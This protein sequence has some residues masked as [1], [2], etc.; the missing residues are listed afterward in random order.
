MIF[1]GFFIRFFKLLILWV[2]KGKK[3]KTAKNGPKWEK[4][5]SHSVSQESY[6][7]WFWFMVLV[8][9]MKIY[10]WG[11]FIF[12]KFWFSGLLGG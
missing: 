9:K 10:P 7:V 4:I 3:C 11:F 6:M 8:C 12:S 1:V 5:M 2:V